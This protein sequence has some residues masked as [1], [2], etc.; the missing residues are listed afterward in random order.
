MIISKNVQKHEQSKK[1]MILI[2][3]KANPPPPQ[4]KVTLEGGG[5]VGPGLPLIFVL[6]NR[7]NIVMYRPSSTAIGGG[8]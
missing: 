4:S 2:R 5:W 6:E 8:G 3:S 1:K 7:P